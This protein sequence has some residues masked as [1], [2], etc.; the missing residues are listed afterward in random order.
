M[1]RLSALWSS[2]SGYRLAVGGEGGLGIVA[3]YVLQ[4][5]KHSLQQYNDTHALTVQ[6]LHLYCTYSTHKFVVYNKSTRTQQIR[7]YIRTV[8][9]MHTI[10]MCTHIHVHAYIP[11][12]A[13][14]MHAHTP[15]TL[16]LSPSLLNNKAHKTVHRIG[17][18]H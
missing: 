2:W 10:P 17:W 5:S 1:T 16:T 3:S 14:T 13:H 18:H 11:T 4:P 9:N 12:N 6:T 15:H 8:Y 7:T